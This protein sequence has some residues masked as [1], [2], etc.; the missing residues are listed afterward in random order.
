[1][2]FRK[3]FEQ[4]CVGGGKFVLG[5]FVFADPFEGVAA[6][7]LGRAANPFAHKKFQANGLFFVGVSHFFK[8]I[9]CDDFH[10]QFFTNFADEALLK[11]FVGFAFATGKFPKPAKVR[12]CVAARDQ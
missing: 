7:G 1:M 4:S 6:K 12:P 10:S 8:Q 2:R 9:A 11:G 3:F 5:H